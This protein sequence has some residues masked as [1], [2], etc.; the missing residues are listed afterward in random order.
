M[1]DMIKKPIDLSEV[2]DFST[3]KSTND[4]QG[5][6]KLNDMLSKLMKKNNCVSRNEKV[7]VLRSF[8]LKNFQIFQ[9]IPQPIEEPVVGKE[10]K[11]RKLD[12][13]VLGLSAAKE[14]KTIF[15]EPLSSMKK[16]QI[17]PS[18]SV[19]PSS[20]QSLSGNSNQQQSQKPFTITLTSVP[21]N[22]SKQSSSSSSNAS[23]LAALQGMANIGASGSG[24]SSNTTKDSLTA[25]FEQQ[26]KQQ[27]KLLQQLPANSPQRKTY[28][29]MFAEMRQTA[30]MRFV[31]HFYKIWVHLF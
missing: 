24:S 12:E 1:A 4:S 19:T 20:A 2:Q 17:P 7:C 6:G 27:Q 16:P 3:K 22:S 9:F 5:K 14:Q 10:K 25:L 26:A 13:I 15:P 11:R 30:E 8:Y 29:A 21:S 28:E 31:F 18:V 23:G